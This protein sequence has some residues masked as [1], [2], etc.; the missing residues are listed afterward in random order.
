MLGSVCLGSG[1]LRSGGVVGGGRGQGSL[2]LRGW[3]QGS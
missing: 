2:S 3:G 1:E